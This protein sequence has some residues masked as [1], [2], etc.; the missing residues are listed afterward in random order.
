MKHATS[1]T[2]S[3]VFALLIIATVFNRPC[4]AAAP[5]GII[6]GRVVTGNTSIAGA[7]VTLYG[8]VLTCVPDPCTMT[9]MAVAKTRT[10]AQG[11][12]AIDLAKASVQ[13]PTPTDNYANAN[14]QPKN[15]IVMKTERP[16]PGSL[17]LIASGGDAGNGP[18]PSIG[19]M[20]ALGEVANHVTIN[21][22]TTVISAFTL[23]RGFMDQSGAAPASAPFGLARALVDVA[24]GQPQPI[25][26]E[27]RNRP[28][29]IDTLA[30][31]ISAC[32]TSA[33]P[34]FPSCGK[35]F[36]A[37]S[38]L[39]M[40]SSAKPVT[41][42]DTLAAL[43]AI[44]ANPGVNVP[45]VFAMKPS[46][47][48]YKPVL[49]AAPGAWLFTVN[50]TGGFSRPTAVAAERG[51]HALWIVNSGDNRLVGLDTDP[52][53]FGARLCAKDGLALPGMSRSAA[54]VMIP[55]DSGQVPGGA[56]TAPSLW[57]ANRGS[58]SVDVVNLATCAARQLTGNGLSAPAGIATFPNNTVY[59]SV[60]G[61]ATRYQ[62]VSVVNSG[63]DTVSFFTLDGSACGKP[64]K[65]LG[66]KNPGAATI[67]PSPSQADTCVA[68]SGANEILMLR[69]PD[70]RCENAA[71]A[72]RLS[73]GGLKEPTRII[74]N[75]HDAMLWVTNRAGDSVSA[76]DDSGRPLPGSPFKGGGLREPK[77]I[78]FDGA[79]NLWIANHARG[80]DTVTELN[81]RISWLRGSLEPGAPLSPAAG[82]TGA[83][84]DR[85]YGIA[86]DQLGDVWVTNP[87]NDSVTAF[88]GAAIPPWQS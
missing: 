65:N 87:G 69:S 88:I 45:A 41:P 50:F 9:S 86:I 18:N 53:N 26:R 28:A 63:A 72:G 19:L 5:S 36:A 8:V 14:G 29:L 49:A 75:L 16:M 47:P 7:T 58:D 85:P 62:I 27:G 37:V 67:C 2:A 23:G 11:N 40:R 35:L 76:F 25:L 78:A 6:S 82:F 57:I 33:A 77:G 34:V 83:G 51:N 24:T 55:G 17:Y 38:S 80:A 31:I 60:G 10:D 73:G 4:A 20:L 13:V 79:G 22:L 66:L 30:D 44:L 61:R 21:E 46:D 68:N 15:E 1:H 48:P 59:M 64:L 74:Y 39:A 84:L 70:V 56:R 54:M 43:Q 71:L 42:H 12:F 81:G 32:V 52:A 3:V